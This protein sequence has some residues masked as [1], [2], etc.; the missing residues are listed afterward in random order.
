MNAVLADSLLSKYDVAGPRYTSY[1]TVPYWE[2]TPS[3]AQWVEHIG[4]ALHADAEHGAALYVHV[5][6]CRAL[7]TFCGCNTRITRSHGFVPPY[8]QAL[9]AELDLYLSRLGLTELE[10]GELHF[11][12]GTPTFLSTDEL[13][14]LLAGLFR[15]MR[16]RVGASAS[17]E[18]D[19]RVTTHAQ[20]Q[21]LARY[22]FRRISLGV[23]DFDPRVQ[24]IVNRVQ[25]EQQVRETT[26]SARELGFDSVNFD[27]IYGLP[28]Q[29]LASIEATMDAVCRLRPDR[30]ALYGYAHVPWI[31]P[32]QRR[33]T[34]ADLPQG[35][36]K[37]ALYELGRE[38]LAR[39][40]YRE[41]GLDHFALESDELWQA[42]TRGQLHRNFMGYT[43]AFTRPLIGLGVS[44]IG[45]AGDAFA[46]NEKDL[47]RYQERVMQGELPIQRGHLLDAEDRVLRSHILRLMTRL[48]T[49]WDEPGQRT[50]WLDSAL[51][52]LAEPAADGLVLLDA[53]GC[54]VTDRGRPFLR[55]ICMA[56]DARLA[57]RMPDKALF[58]RTV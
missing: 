34:E 44:A 51:A 14:A 43:T 19:P 26:Q 27:L 3:E 37:R 35:A 16:A 12:G 22:G 15:R 7:C 48:E 45:D 24:D 58:S 6:F 52:R 1:P 29:T 25:S 9:L 40:G 38:R 50:A 49:H 57:R 28:L 17:I 8:S 33:F 2:S 39:E 31:K 42:L 11:G 53:S 32:G 23:Q 41:I 46:Q 54:R 36:D 13:E 56:F 30:I 47:Q 10:Y 18:V 4:A 21:V 55:N 20:L 5:P